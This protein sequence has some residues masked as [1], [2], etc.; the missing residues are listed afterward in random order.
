[1]LI[2]IRAGR[3]WGRVCLAVVAA[4]ACGA[5]RESDSGAVVEASPPA[6]EPAV[7]AH[8]SRLSGDLALP[9]GFPSDI[10]QYPGA[11]LTWSNS[12]ESGFLISLSTTDDPGDVAEYFQ[13]QLTAQ[14]WLAEATN[15]PAGRSV[16]AVKGK[17]EATVVITT[18]S[19][20]TNIDVI[21]LSGG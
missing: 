4:L 19:D 11:S 2:S 18:G 6:A 5:E 20:T 9:D 1:M 21:L 7:H 13:E 3:P 17:R 16:I 15:Q 12:D 14:G 10:P 8:D